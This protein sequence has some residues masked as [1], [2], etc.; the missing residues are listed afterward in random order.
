[1]KN[2]KVEQLI[3]IAKRR[4]KGSRDPIHDLDHVTRVA[5]YAEEFVVD[6][7]LDDTQ[8]DAVVLAAWWHDMARTMTKSPSFLWMSVIDDTLSS[9]ML[10][11]ETIRCGLFGTSVGLAAKIILCK[12]FGTGAIFTKLLL[13]KE[14]RV[15][16]DIV[17]DADSIDMLHQERAARLMKLADSSLFYHYGY[18]IILWWCIKTT[19]LHV[20]TAKAK[21][22]LEAILTKFLEWATQQQIF[23]WHINKFG[24]KWVK[25]TL[26]DAE[27]LLRNVVAANNNMRS[28]I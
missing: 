22:Y 3:E 23:D 24:I 4:M 25:K 28:G 5:G 2:S 19:E 9:I 7:G 21:K 12:S 14:N 26:A 6:S 15:L 20:K 13:K 11:F 10:W 16:V 1:M 18:K 27:Q 8:K 17:K